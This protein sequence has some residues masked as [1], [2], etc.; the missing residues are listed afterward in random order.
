[1]IRFS[2]VAIF[3]TMLV[4]PAVLHG[5]GTDLGSIRGDVTDASGAAVPNATVTITDLATDSRI[6]V[7][8]SQ[9]G[10]YEANGLRSG[11]YKVNVAAAGF[12]TL[13]ISGITLGT[14]S[15]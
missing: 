3:L 8:T 11:A 9:T 7:K 15:T 10:E 2:R 1:M 5:Q 12:G 14:G 4:L 6:T 13:E